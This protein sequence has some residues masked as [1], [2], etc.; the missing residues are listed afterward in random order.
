MRVFLG[1][2]ENHPCDPL[3]LAAEAKHAPDTAIRLIRH[4]GVEEVDDYI[5]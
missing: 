4:K 2:V 3:E 1:L 5:H